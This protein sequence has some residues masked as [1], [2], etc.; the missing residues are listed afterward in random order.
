MIIIRLLALAVWIGAVFALAMDLWKMTDTGIFEPTA[1]GS[2]W[3]MLD[4]ESLTLAQNFV[5]RYVS[6]ILWNPGIVSLLKMPAWAVLGGLAVVLTV[7]S[8]MGRGRKI[9]DRP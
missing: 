9:G 3:Y 7:I 5:E 2:L 1:L 8:A 6:E 4:M